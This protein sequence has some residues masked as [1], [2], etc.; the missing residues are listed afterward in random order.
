[1]K[2]WIRSCLLA[3]TLTAAPA[4]AAVDSAALDAWLKATM[5][6]HRLAGMTAVIVED[7][8]VA[9]LRSYGVRDVDTG[10]PVTPQ[11]LFH[12]ASVSKALVGVAV[13]QLVEEGKID[14]SAPVSRYLPY[15]AMADD[16]VGEVTIDR[17]LAH[18]AGMPDV[19]DY[20]WKNPQTDDGALERWVRAQA[21]KSLLFAPGSDRRYSNI[22]YEVLG[23]VIAKVSGMSFEAYMKA[24]VFAP[25]GMTASTFLRTDVPEALGVRAHVGVSGT[26]GLDYYPYNRRH[27][28]SSTF[29]TNG[30]ELARWL[31]AFSSRERL[32]ETG[33]LK[34]DTIERMWTVQ[35]TMADDFKMTRGWFKAS[36]DG[37]SV[38]RHGG[39]DDG[40]LS[41]MAVFADRDAGYG[42]MLNKDQAPLVAIRAALR[43][44]AMDI[45]LPELPGPSRGQKIAALFEEKG[46]QAVVDHF[47]EVLANDGGEAELYAVY[48]FANDRLMAGDLVNA[49]ALADGML[50]HFDG[51]PILHVFQGEAKLAL[52]KKAEARKAAENALALRP[53]AAAVLDLLARIGAE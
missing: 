43:N 28:P 52:G 12:M 14:L 46:A 39:G 21:G 33:L 20:E 24:H 40:F 53:D 13:M 6:S 5:E 26:Y 29:H 10:A 11:N 23:D 9:F 15:F 27:A 22:G 34:P 47:G 25:L 51:L 17:L 18:T 41:E 30:E 3:V 49:E 44:A 36:G 45:P 1:M 35:F 2:N 32:A 38:Y 4:A 16:R 8:K 37:F 50:G 19:D 48:F 31:I 7:G 42:L